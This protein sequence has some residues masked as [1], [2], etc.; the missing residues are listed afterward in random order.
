MILEGRPTRLASGLAAVLLVA[1]RL[2]RLRLVFA[3]AAAKPASREATRDMEAGNIVRCERPAG[4]PVAGAGPAGAEVLFRL[5]ESELACGRVEQALAA[6]SQVPAEQ[7]IF[8]SSRSRTARKLALQTGPI[9]RRRAHLERSPQGARLKS[10]SRSG[11][12]CSSS[13]ASRDGCSRRGGSSRKCGQRLG[14][15]SA[16]GSPCFA[17]TSHSTSTRCRSRE[18]SSSWA[19]S[20]PPQSDDDGLWLARANLATKTGRLEE[21]ERWLDAACLRRPDDPD[22]W[23]ARLDWAVTAGRLD[24]AVE[25]MAHLGTKRPCP[26][27]DRPAGRL[28]RPAKRRTSRD[29]KLALEQVV[30]LDPGD[31]PR[32]ERLAELAFEEGREADGRK[33]RNRKSEL[34][35]LKDRYRRLFR[36]GQLDRKRRRDGSPGRIAGTKLRSTGFP[37]ARWIRE[38]PGDPSDR[39]A[40]ARLDPRTAVR[41]IRGRVARQPLRAAIARP[42]SPRP[43]AT[44]PGRS[45]IA[46]ENDAAA[47]GLAGFRSRQRHNCGPPASRDVLRRNRR[48]RL[49]RRRLARRLCHPGRAVPTPGRQSP[50]GRP[51]LPEPGR[52][53][54]RRRHARERNRRH[55]GRLRPRSLGRRL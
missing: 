34:D 51:A 18:T 53:H 4:I 22:V 48:P 17:T 43:R 26:R 45:S 35:A 42:G 24:R 52:R 28:A 27:R 32:I 37:D 33:L 21:A 47:A 23:R 2:V 39:A 1:T 20:G 14:S 36:E 50:A 9:L 13:S 30:A 5:G 38:H 54:I 19:R 7:L 44:E 11:I 6:W 55:A 29:E 12:C 10:R 16:S 49:R 31:L 25:A 41:P 46:F 40:L 3:A 15:H 8:R